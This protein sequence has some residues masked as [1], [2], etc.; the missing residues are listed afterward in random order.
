MNR[1][2]SML[3]IVVIGGGNGS[4]ITLNAIKP[5]AGKFNISAVISMSDSGG[6]S[7]KLRREMGVLPPGDILRAILAMSPYDYAVLKRIFHINRFNSGKLAGHNLG[8]MFLVWA[9]KFN[10]NYLHALH[11]LA[12][13]VEAVGTV[14]PATLDTTDLQ[15]K[16]ENGKILRSEEE[17]DRPGSKKARIVK[18]W[19]KPPGTIF[20]GAKKAIE[21]ADYVL[22][23]PGS[24]YT[25]IVAALLPSGVSEA[26]KKSEA[27]L[28]YVM[29][30]AF[31]KQGETGPIRM[32]EFV[33]ELQSYLP[34][35]ID[36][37]VYNNH[38]LTAAEKKNY[39]QRHW[40]TFAVDKA[41]LR[42]Y[43]I[44]AGDYEREG[45][46]LCPEK[47][48]KVLRSKVLK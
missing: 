5:Y 28:I 8:N 22:M 27:K 23:G 47:L 19:L 14:H 35:K 31:E 16:L 44:I 13:A 1:S 37:V 24:L 2:K 11:A 21:N 41:N 3:N 48:G 46:G 18:A 39:C 30:N 26:I 29:G 42:G 40:Q 6:S 45:G 32:S 15:V 36:L 25:S 10:G 17:I 34:R 9:E 43:N 4:A 33:K 38:Q 7:G 20:T 12:E